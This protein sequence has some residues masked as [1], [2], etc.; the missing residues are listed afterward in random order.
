MDRAGDLVKTLSSVWHGLKRSYVVIV[1]YFAFLIGDSKEEA[2]YF[3][4]K[5]VAEA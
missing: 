3:A 4:I 5:T 2:K 1:M